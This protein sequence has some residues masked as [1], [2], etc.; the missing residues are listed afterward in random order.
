MTA[1]DNAI[2]KGYDRNVFRMA[3]IN[4]IKQSDSDVQ[5]ELQ[6]LSKKAEVP[7]DT[8]QD[9]YK[10]GSYISSTQAERIAQILGG[11]FENNFKFAVQW[12][13]SHKELSPAVTK[14][15]ISVEKQKIATETDLSNP[16]GKL[17][18]HYLE[19][20]NISKIELLHEL[21]TQ[22]PNLDLQLNIL[23]R[24]ANGPFKNTPTQREILKAVCDYVGEDFNKIIEDYM[25]S[26]KIAN[27]ALENRVQTKPTNEI[28]YS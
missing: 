12:M 27:P 8:L 28:K 21:N 25:P 5:S 19:E 18:N 17:V 20:N 3:L 26:N 2:Y 24:M 14:E 9:F 7:L 22:Y 11:E 1:T 16:L 6:V 4:S 13:S 15:V 23:T 10:S